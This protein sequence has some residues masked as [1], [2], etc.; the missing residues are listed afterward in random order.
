MLPRWLNVTG[1]DRTSSSEVAMPLP[2]ELVDAPV[3][4]KGR[5]V[6]DFEVGAVLDHHWGRT[7]TTTDNALF[8]SATLAYHPRYVNA[9]YRASVGAAETV[10][11]M[12]VFCSVLGL[13]VEDLSEKG[14]AFLGVDDLVHHRPVDVGETVF[15]RSEVLE[16]RDSRSRPTQG[17]VRWRT[18]GYVRDAEGREEPVVSYERANLLP[19]RGRGGEDRER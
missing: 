5:F 14:G 19:R 15:A 2:A 6:E 1:P 18:E 13:S 7:F 10:H 17:I 9:A 16:V 12:M 11:P 4:E 3:W 8:V